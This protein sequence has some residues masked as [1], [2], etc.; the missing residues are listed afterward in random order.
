MHV[1]I[2]WEGIRSMV[3]PRLRLPRFV[4]LC[5]MVGLL[6]VLLSGC[7][8]T[9]M[10]PAGQNS[11]S[12]ENAQ[13]TFN[14]SVS[15]ADVANGSVGQTVN[16]YDTFSSVVTAFTVNSARTT[17]DSAN[18]NANTVMLPPGEQF[19]VLTLT[20]KNTSASATSCANPKA[21]NCVE[22]VSPLQNFRLRDSQGRDWPTT[23]GALET[24]STDPHTMC[25]AREWMNEALNGIAPGQSFTTQL[26]FIVPT[27]GNLAL[28]FAP[29]RFTDASPALAGGTYSGEHQ[30]TVAVIS[31]NV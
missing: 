15:P 5:A 6:G 21:N 9:Q 18:L 25:A 8:L 24:C 2:D 30:A 16:V 7:G 26:A 17:M 1:I 29:Y 28:Y 14:F 19:L 20:M 22:Y 11:G 31:I 13:G 4:P 27:Q 23:S 12:P 10:D 3:F